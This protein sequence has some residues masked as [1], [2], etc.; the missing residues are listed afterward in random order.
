[1]SG[2]APRFSTIVDRSV[3]STDTLGA[4]RMHHDAV[5]SVDLR[6]SRV[7]FLIGSWEDHAE[8]RALM[9]L[10]RYGERGGYNASEISNPGSWR[11]ADLAPKTLTVASV[12]G[13]G[14]AAGE[15]NV[16][17]GRQIEARRWR[18]FD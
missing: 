8:R 3:E 6:T 16:Y 10:P 9:V 15:P 11:P 4:G 13:A 18:E 17:E 12:T 2:S 5:W 1:M 7:K 14:S